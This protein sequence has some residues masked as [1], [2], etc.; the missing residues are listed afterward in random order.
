[1]LFQEQPKILDACVLEKKE[2][3]EVASHCTSKEAVFTELSLTSCVREETSQLVI[4]LV[5]NLY[6][7]RSLL[8]KISS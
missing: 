6:T 3:G 5:A 7:A 1:M 8:M 2:R 4:E